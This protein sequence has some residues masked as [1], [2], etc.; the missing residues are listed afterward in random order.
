[1]KARETVTRSDFEE[2][3]QFGINMFSENC[4]PGEV[5][6]TLGLNGMGLS[7]AELLPYNFAFQAPEFYHISTPMAL[8][9]PLERRLTSVALGARKALTV[10]F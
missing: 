5:D 7:R 3:A 4:I 1:M 2:Q 8:E 6:S 10:T 9:F